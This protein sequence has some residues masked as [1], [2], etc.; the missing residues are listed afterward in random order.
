MYE[1]LNKIEHWAL[2]SGTEGM[3]KEWKVIQH[4][5]LLLVRQ[6]YQGV[7][8]WVVLWGTTQAK[9]GLK[10]EPGDGRWLGGTFGTTQVQTC[11]GGCLRWLVNLV[12]SWG[13]TRTETWIFMRNGSIHN[14]VG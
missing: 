5:W 6:R 4:D 7:S 14:S 13:T 8:Y 3:K 2:G 11:V 12:L 10:A 9:D 1:S